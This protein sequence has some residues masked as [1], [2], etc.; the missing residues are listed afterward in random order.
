MDVRAA[1]VAAR[2]AFARGEWRLVRDRLAPVGV[3]LAPADRDLLGRATWLLGDVPGSMEHAEQAFAGYVAQGRDVTA[4]ELAL[5]LSIQWATR[6]D[7]ALAGAWFAR[8]RRLLEDVPAC[9]ATGYLR[10]TAVLLAPQ[11]DGDARST[12]AAAEDVATL[13]AELGDPT[14]GCFARVL[15]GVAAIRDGRVADGFAALDEA[16]LPVLAGQVDPLWAGDI[17]CA[18]V[19]ACEG[20]ADLTRMRAWTDAMARWARPFPDDLVYA[21]VTRVHQLQLLAAEGDW[22]AVEA[23]VAELSERLATAHSWVAGSGFVELGDIRRLRGDAPGARRA[24]ARARAVG[25]EPQP[26]EAELLLT[27]GH[28]AEALESLLGAVA[29]A[30]RLD[31][32]RLLLPAVR[33]AITAGDLGLAE[34]LTADLDA[35]AAYFASPGLTA[36][37]AQARAAVL[38]ARSQPAAAV[39]HLE[40]ALETYREQRYRYA[41]AQVHEQLAAAHAALGARAAG[42]AAAATARAIYARLGAAPDVARLDAGQRP[43]QLPAGLTAREAEVLVCVAAGGSNREVAARLYISEKTVG[44]HLANIFL[45]IGVSSRTAAGAW[46]HAHGLT[47]G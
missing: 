44:R 14:L 9:A 23:E 25:V 15:H 41:M 36:R 10:Y 29:A 40:T 27:E 5:R 11:I 34:H 45:K 33:C 35:V 16:M 8:A 20:L 12:A 31:G 26:G 17:Y 37:A 7:A 13:A 30:G 32:A 46:A 22:D 18:V 4:A 19:H 43:D 28:V 24:Y 21:G 3:A 6:G 42:A 38:L 1:Q 47:G 39:P 2:E